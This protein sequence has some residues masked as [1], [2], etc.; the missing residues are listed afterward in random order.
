MASLLCGILGL[1]LFVL[2]IPA[3]ILGPVAYFMGRR[4][5]RRIAE[6]RGVLAGHAAAYAGWLI[7][8]IATAF[9]AAA[10]LFWFVLLLLQVA[11]PTI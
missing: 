4:A 2:G 1:V 3:M 5:E 7:G 11:S 6:S 9:G 10:L 8:V